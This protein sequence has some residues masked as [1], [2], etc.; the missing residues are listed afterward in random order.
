MSSK[1]CSNFACSRPCEYTMSGC[2]SATAHI[3]RSRPR[4]ARHHVARELSRWSIAS[5][6][7]SNDLSYAR[8]TWCPRCVSAGRSVCK[9]FS[10]PPTRLRCHVAIRILI[11]PAP[12]SEVGEP[13]FLQGSCETVFQEV[14]GHCLLNEALGVHVEYR[15]D[16]DKVAWPPLPGDFSPVRRLASFG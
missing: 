2:H 6:T 8:P 9:Y 5:R 4:S 10:A 7:G 15:S 12:H 16:P 11:L 14:I 13:C 1:A 3:R